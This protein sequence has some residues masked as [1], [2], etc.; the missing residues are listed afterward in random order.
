MMPLLEPEPPVPPLQIET[1]VPDDER[2]GLE[3]TPFGPELDP[4]DREYDA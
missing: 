1:E 2:P 3:R 4:D